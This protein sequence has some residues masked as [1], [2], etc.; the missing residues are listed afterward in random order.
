M[1]TF[2]I[3]LLSQVEST[4][5]QHEEESTASRQLLV[6]REFFP[7][8]MSTNGTIAIPSTRKLQQELQTYLRKNVEIDASIQQRVKRSNTNRFRRGIESFVF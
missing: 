6:E 7:L 3:V 1:L 4:V 8:S 2:L 5:Q